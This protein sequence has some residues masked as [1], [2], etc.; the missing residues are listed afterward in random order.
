MD[1]LLTLLI[2]VQVCVF[3]LI[4]AAQESLQQENSSI[5]PGQAESV[6]LWDNMQQVDS[7]IAFCKSNPY[8]CELASGL[9]LAATTSG[10]E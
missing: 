10:N 5:E 6:S 8:S 3:N 7:N 4:A 1:L 9:A 2:R